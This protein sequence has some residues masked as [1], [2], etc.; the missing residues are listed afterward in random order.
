MLSHGELASQYASSVEML[1]MRAHAFATH[2]V[3]TALIPP[4]PSALMVAATR[5]REKRTHQQLVVTG[6]QYSPN[7]A[8][9]WHVGSGVVSPRSAP[10]AAA[11]ASGAAAAVLEMVTSPVTLSGTAV[12]NVPV[13]SG[14]VVVAEAESVAAPDE[15]VADPESVASRRPLVSSSSSVLMYLSQLLR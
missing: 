2:V 8:V 9:A 5:A 4:H 13:L 10:T 7:A 15:S 12:R 6:S 3:P 1:Q 11:V 14:A